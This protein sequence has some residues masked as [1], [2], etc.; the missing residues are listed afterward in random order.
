M[1]QSGETGIGAGRAEAGNAPL[2]DTYQQGRMS[3]TAC[4]VTLARSLE[5]LN[6][7]IALRAAA[8]FADPEH[9]YGKHFDGND[10]SASHMIGYIG[11]EPVGTLRIRYFGDFARIERIAVRPTHRRSRIAFKM[12]HAA[13]AFCRDK[14]YRKL[15]GVAREEMVPFWSMFGG[16]LT[17]SKEPVF[18]YGLPHLEMSI[19]YPE[20][21]T[22]VTSATDTMVVLRPEGRWH[23]EGAYRRRSEDAR[24]VEA[25]MP[26]LPPKTR[27]AD[28][29][30][31]IAAK[32]EGGQRPESVPAIRIAP[33]ARPLRDQPDAPPP[34]QA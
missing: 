13:V 18:I 6:K 11:D 1:Y 32:R 8:Y 5:D 29:A 14:G 27:P 23:E 12:V 20:L 26:V 34:Q 21:P 33:P 10:L 25:R 4:S 19:E 17:A 15:S 24:P 31:R 30:R 28:L 3:P 22:A 16:R 2:Y 7:V 9:S